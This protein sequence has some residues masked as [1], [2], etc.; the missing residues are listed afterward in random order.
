MTLL[1]TL[2]TY[3]YTHTGQ[4]SAIGSAKKGYL[5]VVFVSK[6]KITQRR[7]GEPQRNP[8][9]AL[10]VSAVKKRKD[11]KVFR[12]GDGVH[13]K[14]SYPVIASV[15]KQSRAG[16]ADDADEAFRLRSM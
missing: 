15:A 2:L 16:H 7:H 3:T 11:A 14:L 10:C 13:F 8:C 1:I 9:G 6:I 5:F 12:K 4:G